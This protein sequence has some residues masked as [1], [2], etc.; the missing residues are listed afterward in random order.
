L[1]KEGGPD[2][3]IL[4]ES[5]TGQLISWLT[6]SP[7]SSLNLSIFNQEDENMPTRKCNYSMHGETGVICQQY[8]TKKP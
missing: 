4:E 5:V 1:H 6:L 8:S 7:N 2:V 3:V